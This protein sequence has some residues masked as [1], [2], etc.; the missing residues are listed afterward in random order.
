MQIPNILCYLCTF[1]EYFPALACTTGNTTELIKL[2]N[3]RKAQSG[4]P[5][6]FPFT[7]KGKIYHTCTYDFSH[8]TYYKPWCSTNVDETGKH[9]SG[10]NADGSRNWGICDENEK[11]LDCPIPPRRKLSLDTNVFM[12]FRIFYTIK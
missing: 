7:L 4:V 10:R 2:H 5:C 8:T 11:P 12:L 6:I 9:V 3:K 1:I